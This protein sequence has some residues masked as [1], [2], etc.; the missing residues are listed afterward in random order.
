MESVEETVADSRPAQANPTPELLPT[1][2]QASFQRVASS[3]GFDN[4]RRSRNSSGGCCG[5]CTSLNLGDGYCPIKILGRGTS[6]TVWET[7]EET[8]RRRWAVKVFNKDKPIW[9]SRQKQAIREFRLLEGL[10]H[11]AIIKAQWCFD[12]PSKFCIVFE[13]MDGGSLRQLLRQSPYRGL[14]AERSLN[15][16]KQVCEGV[17]F[18][19]GRLVAHRD[20]KLENLLLDALESTVK[21]VDFGFAVQLKSTDQRLR[22][23][24]GTPS[25]MAPEIVL[26]KSYNGFS[27]DV[28]ALGV[29]LYALLSGRFPFEAATESQLYA[30]VRRGAF[31]YPDSIGPLSRRAITACM[32]MDDAGRPSVNQLLAHPLLSDISTL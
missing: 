7:L 16:L 25:Y 4:Q 5:V 30:K 20:L 3:S 1:A 8:S 14:G 6:A 31:T 9:K 13:L 10:A 29:V 24:C 19:H 32:R 11:P 28:W 17:S 26:G 21:I 12:G 22:A 15:L 23:F 18:C 2:R 27:T